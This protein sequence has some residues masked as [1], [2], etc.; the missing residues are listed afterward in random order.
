MKKWQRLL[1]FAGTALAAAS[2]VACGSSKSAST[3][4]DGDIKLLMY[5]IGEKPENFDKL[6]EIANKRIKE[7]TGATLDMQYI[8]WGEWGDKMST[9]IASGENYD[10]AYAHSYVVNAQKGAFADLTELMPKYAKETYENMEPAYIK[11]NLVNGKLYAFPVDA[12]VYAQQM[13]SFN[14]KFLDKYNL[15]IS[16]INSYADA[17]PILKAFH[18][19]EPNVAAFAIGQV[20]NLSGD[21]DYPLNKNNP[22][23]VKVDAGKATIINP[24]AEES[25]KANLRLMHKWYQEGLIPSDAAT[26][27]EGYPLDG[28]TWFMREETQGPMDYGDTILT[29]A[30]G[31]EIV[32]R[33][34][35]KALKTTS[36][37]QMANFVVSSVSKHKE[38]S[39]E[40][41]ALLNS[42]PELL[43]GLVY[44]VEGEGWEKVGDKKIKLL[45]GY[46]PGTHMS[47]WNTGNNKILYTQE[48]ITDEMIAKRDQSIKEAAE[49][50]ILGFT[51][52]TDNI[53][54]ELSNIS[55][56][57]NR[58]KASLN[59]GTVDPD[60]TLPKFLSDLK[61]AGWDKVQADLQTQLDKF[62]ASNKK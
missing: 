18:E 52:N 47:A 20:F 57:M 56:V 16:G 38:K 8:G 30:A 31:K 43:N 42:D 37:A 25:F 3:E 23:A 44:G 59:T 5:Q 53:K 24:Y 39:V 41:L 13:L 12:N 48:S 49:S 19:K 10:I 17:E 15:D 35:T 60:E 54:T 50:P 58:Y 7:K 62:V 11:G 4:K 32:S 55:N 6:M 1:C 61:D 21:Y 46:K 22:F 29:N 14:K 26:N 33:P 2:L 51:V 36:Q 9:I 28:D 45:D 34:L 27:T 40:V